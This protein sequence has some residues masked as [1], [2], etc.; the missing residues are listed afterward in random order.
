MLLYQ[1]FNYLV[2]KAR[3]KDNFKYSERQDNTGVLA[4]LKCPSSEAMK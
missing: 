4:K 2:I 3:K 1:A